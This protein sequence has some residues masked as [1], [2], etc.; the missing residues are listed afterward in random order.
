MTSVKNDE[1]SSE[2]IPLISAHT[3]NMLFMVPFLR[4]G[5]SASYS[6][7]DGDTILHAAAVGWQHH[8]V[9][10][11]ILWGADVCAQNHNGDT[12][13]HALTRSRNVPSDGIFLKGIVLDEARRETFRQL[14]VLGKCDGSIKNVQGANAL[15]LAAH[16]GDYLALSE[17]LNWQKNLI[18]TVTTKGATSLLLAIL[19]GHAR[20][21]QQLVV[22]GADV[23]A[24]ISTGV[25]PIDLLSS[26]EDSGLKNLAEWYRSRS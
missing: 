9:E 25:R 19:G 11:L 2:N 10:F 16:E 14:M 15:H 1:G 21:V 12:A 3:G 24:E 6:N 20:C 22:R 4:E 5:G 13:L 8:M 7:A 18:D 17:I 23:Y 26:S